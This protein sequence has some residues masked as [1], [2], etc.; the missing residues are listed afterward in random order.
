MTETKSHDRSALIQWLAL[1]LLAALG[2]IAA[3]VLT[4]G[5][6][7]YGGHSGAPA[8]VSQQY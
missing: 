4:D 8:S 1:G 5:G 7:G 3:F 6:G 2:L